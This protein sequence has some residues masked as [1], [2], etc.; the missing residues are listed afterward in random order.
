MTIRTEVLS[1]RAALHCPALRRATMGAMLTLLVASPALYAQPESPA[2]VLSRARAEYATV[3]TARAEFTQ[4]IKNPLLGRTVSSRGTLLQRKPDRI[5]VTFT[6]PAGDR[7]VSDGTTLWVY[8]PSSAPGQVMKLPAGDGGTGG[9]DLAATVLDAPR[10]GYSLGDAGARTI[11]GR[12]ARGV[13]LVAKAGADV[14]FPKATV[15]IDNANASVREVQVID[16]T[17]T[18][19]TIRI[20]S[21][22]KN[23]AVDASAFTFKVPSGVRVVQQP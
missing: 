10:E 19:R 14:P 16:E 23:V 17:G 1:S 18:E 13:S 3:R 5:A 2:A 8:I 6:D 22:E 7:I 4:E 11:N 12:A 15:W 21:W 20:V 9:V